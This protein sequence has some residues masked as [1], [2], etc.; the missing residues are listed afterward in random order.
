MSLA[1]ALNTCDQM[2]AI[3]HFIAHLTL[4]S[5]HSFYLPTPYIRIDTTTRTARMITNPVNSMNPL[6]RLL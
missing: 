3:D 6:G 2:N 4:L 1:Q 5:I